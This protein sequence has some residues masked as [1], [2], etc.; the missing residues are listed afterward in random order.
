M[1]ADKL[2]SEHDVIVLGTGMT[3]SI[4]AAALSRI[5]LRVLHLDR[6]DSYGGDWGSF[7]FSALEQWI[8]V[9]KGPSQ[10][11]TKH[12]DLASLL[13]T[14]EKP[15]LLP[16]ES[17]TISNIQEFVYI[18]GTTKLSG[19]EQGEAPSSSISPAAE[20][21][22]SEILP[23]KDAERGAKHAEEDTIAEPASETAE[24]S[25]KKTATDGT[26]ATAE[27][28][29]KK[30]ESKT[31][32]V[33]E[34]TLDFAGVKKQWRK[35]NIDLMPKVL[36]SRGPL[37][38]LLIS[39]DVAKYCEFRSITRVLTLLK[40]KLE[41]VPCSRADVFAS[42]DVSVIEK[43]LLMKFLTFAIE[44]QKHPAQYAGFEERPFVE[45]LKSKLL[46][47]TIQH[48][49]QH[50]IA[51]VTETATTMEGLEAT[52]KFLLSLG[53]YGNTAFLWPL[54]GSG[55]LL[56]CFC[57]M[58]AVF[59]GI[60]CLRRT[61]QAIILNNSDEIVAIVDT[62]GQRL[63]TKWVV[64][65]SSY[66]SSQFLP[67]IQDVSRMSR[68]VLITDRSVRLDKEQHI[69]VM[70]LPLPGRNDSRATVY[71]LSSLSLACPEGFYVV[72]L[73]CHSLAAD[74]KTDL[75][76]IIDVLFQPP[77]QE[78]VD[79]SRPRIIWSLFYNVADTSRTDLTCNAIRN[80][81]VV[82]GPDSSLDCDQ[83]IATARTVFERICPG[84]EFLPKAP[85]PEDIIF[86]D[87]E[88]SPPRESGFEPIP[89]AAIETEGAETV[90]PETAQPSGIADPNSTGTDSGVT[91][92]SSGKGEVV[93]TSGD[94]DA[95]SGHMDVT[96]GDGDTFV[97][98]GDSGQSDCSG[99]EAVASTSP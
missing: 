61:A 64:M 59:G 71:E 80:L 29:E 74:A 1:D 58:C 47:E 39:S 31:E 90:N 56:Q 96:S 35:F 95:T 48:Y 51:M 34:K 97:A 65:D 81:V 23:N 94:A 18:P 28:S 30:T 99:G 52:Q 25:E 86:D 3:E 40:G 63:E 68:A 26:Q 78:N 75:Q 82:G 45:F 21:G 79:D 73:I 38:E 60:Y 77:E 67:Q 4:I 10:S 11:Q 89:E 2:P 46:T 83:S 57:R 17:S 24:A 69:T 44:F 87:G 54:Y 92:K 12:T 43:R 49:V 5:G 7:N 36:Y 55:E 15:L 84:E 14:D 8:S 93:V 76:P 98:T 70:S 32:L 50:A 66:A 33:E 20:T 6:N 42:H 88:G 9:L 85:N 53:R 62:E 22:S 16:Q 27:S 41:L 19:D 37:V 13:S 91:S 72:H